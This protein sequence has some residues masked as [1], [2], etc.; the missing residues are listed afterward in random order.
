MAR[1]KETW[2]KFS[3]LQERMGKDRYS[4]LRERRAPLDVLVSQL[5][6][7]LARTP[8]E[9]QQRIRDQIMQVQQKMTD[10]DRQILSEQAKPGPEVPAEYHF[11]HGNV[12]LGCS[13]TRRPSSST[14]GAEDRTG[15]RRGCQ[16]TWRAST[17][18]QAIRKGAGGD[19]ESQSSGR[20][21]PELKKAI[22]GALRQAP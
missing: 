7:L 12:L 14:S 4:A 19:H 8:P 6:D 22:E 1:A 20:G 17:T 3:A 9:Q 18:R 5:T 10:L 21:Q 13:S 11:F 15:V 2:V 16:T